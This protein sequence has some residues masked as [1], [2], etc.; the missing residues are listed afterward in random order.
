MHAL[1]Q[2]ER[3]VEL[4]GNPVPS[5]AQAAGAFYRGVSVTADN[6]GWMGLLRRLG[7]EVEVFGADGLAFELR[8]FLGEERFH[9]FEHFIVAPR[10]TVPVHASPLELL[11]EPSDP[12]AE[13]ETSVRELIEVG[14]SGK[15]INPQRGKPIK[16]TR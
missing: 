4:F 13:K 16:Q 11:F 2:F 5:V 9:Q 10:A 14:K 8:N 3:L 12:H 15:R 7:I 1:H 6:V